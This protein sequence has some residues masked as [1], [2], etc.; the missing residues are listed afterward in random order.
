M[1][2]VS[3]WYMRQADPK[4]RSTGGIP[5]LYNKYAGH[6]NNRDSYMSNLAETTAINRQMFIEWIPQ[7]MYNQHQTGPGGSVLFMAPFRDPFNYNY[8]PLVPMGIELVGMAIHNRFIAEG[9]PGAV[10]R[11]AANYSTWF[12]GGVRTTVGF[13]NQIGL[14]S[15]M[16]R[17]SHAHEHSAL[18]RRGLCPTGTSRTRSCPRNGISASRSNT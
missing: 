7:I 2:L 11:G 4:M 8:D 17:Q 6:D 13:H 1:D 14:L 18:C 16:H 12:N 15:E 9:K 5:V 3:N 10:T